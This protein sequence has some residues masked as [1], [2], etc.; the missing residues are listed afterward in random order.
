MSKQQM[1]TEAMEESNGDSISVEAVFTILGSSR[2]RYALHYLRRVDGPVTIRDLS[3]QLAAWETGKERT[4]VRPKER[5]RLYTALHQT[6]LPRM[7]RLGVV[8]YD[9]NRGIVTLSDTSVIFDR[10]LD[11]ARVDN[12]FPWEW[13]SLAIGGVLAAVLGVAFL[14]VAP[15]SQVSA[16]VYATVAVVVLVTTAAAQVLI[17]YH[18]WQ[19]E[20]ALEPSRPPAEIPNQ[21]G[22]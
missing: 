5:K 21:F 1:E 8:E 19:N 16:S 4:A 9:Q 15:F 12:A 6:H 14:G 18:R 22:K 2:R 13:V 11:T 3:E 7:D 17:N 20:K 10:Y